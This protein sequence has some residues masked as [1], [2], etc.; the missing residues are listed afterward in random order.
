MCGG[1]GNSVADHVELELQYP[2]SVMETA[3]N[4]TEVTLQSEPVTC[5]IRDLFS[6]IRTK[7]AIY[8]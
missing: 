8:T 1:T 5:K 7:M 4:V 2:A 6:K 3:Q